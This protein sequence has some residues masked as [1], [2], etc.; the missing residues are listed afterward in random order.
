MVASSQPRQSPK[1]R[2]IRALPVRP[3]SFVFSLSTFSSQ[4][5]TSAVHHP[6]LQTLQRF[7]SPLFSLFVL[8]VLINSF[9]I[10]HFRTLSQNCRGVPF[11]HLKNLQQHLKSLATKISELRIA[12]NE[13]S[14]NPCSTVELT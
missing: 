1:S 8:R 7:L 6:N 13:Q 11:F 4:L 12:M 14:I 10:N 9:P 5:S 2:P 3:S